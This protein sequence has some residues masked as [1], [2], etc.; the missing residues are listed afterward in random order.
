MKYLVSLFILLTF[1]GCSSE[2]SETASA[3]SRPAGATASEI[4]EEK[5]TVVFQKQKNP[6]ELEEAAA[7]VAA[8]LEADLGMPVE[9]VI[10]T[11]Y[12]ASVQ[13]LVSGKAD[14]A[15]LSSIPYLLADEEVD[16]EVLLVELRE[17]RTDYDSIFVVAKD[18]PYQ[19]LEDLRG[20]RMMFT[21]TTST[22]GYVMA[23]SRLVNDGLLEKAQ[24]PEEFFETIG[25]AGGYDRALLSVVNGTADLAAVSY[26]TMEGPKAD[27]YLKEEDR[28][29]LRVLARTSGVPTHL[30]CARAELSD[31]LKNKV[32]ESFLK[33]SSEQSELIADVYGAAKF[34][35]ATEEEHLATARQALENTGLASTELVK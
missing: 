18:S 16:M 9:I 27:L 19:S 2:S 29:K 21:S 14:V 4:K 10:P 35:K 8:A 24:D 15:Y 31:E 33:I 22:S 13:A 1:V 6:E 17:D 28:N 25:Y 30:I 23:Y 5:L 11:S 32:T 7:K 12:V 34:V 3:E 26:Y 20:K